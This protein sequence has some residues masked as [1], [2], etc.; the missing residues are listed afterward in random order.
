MASA[1][2]WWCCHLRTRPVSAC[3]G[4]HGDDQAGMTSW[5]LNWRTAGRP[6][7]RFRGDIGLSRIFVARFA[8][9]ARRNSFVPWLDARLDPAADGGPRWPNDR[10]V[11]RRLGVYP[12]VRWRDRPDSRG[13]PRGGCS[14]SGAGD[15]SGLVP[16]VLAS[17]ALTA[18]IA[19]LRA[20]SLRWPER[21]A[22]ELLR[23]VNELLGSAAA[24]VGPAAGSSC[25]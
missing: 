5:Y 9:A 12:C 11:P 22:G 25:A 10:A 13:R 6:V 20:A 15:L 23:E 14:P 16:A 8:A 3:G 24:C 18:L 21:R 1:A 2:S 7:P 19:G 17:L 4:R